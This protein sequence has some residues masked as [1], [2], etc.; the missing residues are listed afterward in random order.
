MKNIFTS[1]DIGSNN[2]K[3]VVCELHNNKLNLLAASS[4]SSKGI[5][6][7][8]IVNADE[9]SKSIKEAFEKVESMLGIK[10]KKVIA[11]IPSYFAEFTYIKGT[12]NVVNEENLIGSDE[13]VDVLGVAMESKLTNDKEMVTIIPVDFKVDDKG[14]I[15][16]PLGHSG[17]LLSARA[18]MVTTPK[19]NI[20]SV[21]SVLENLGIEV[22]DI[23]INGIGNIYSLKTRDMSDLVGAVIDIG[24]ETTTVSLYNKTVIVKNS[25]IGVGSKVLDNDLAFTYKIG[26]DDAKKIKE[27]FA[28]ASKKYASVG[29]FYEVKNEL[30]EDIKINQFEATE[31]VT[32]RLDE[33]LELVK[34]EILSLSGREL[35]Y[36]V[37]TGGMSEMTHFELLINEKFGKKATVGKIRTIGVRNNIYSASLGNIIYF[38][39]KLKLKGKNYSMVSTK[40][41][42]DLSSVKKNNA[43]LVSD[44]MLGKV[45]Q[46]F[47]GE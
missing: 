29:D 37:F 5:K 23:M 34:N 16:N 47:F 25:I 38:V 40:D 4:V 6:R 41:S 13:V 27:T 42:E 24:S 35:D 39:N 14:G 22:I 44:S 26:K 17:K 15:S 32:N 19:K 7:G 33:I 31:V 20:Y 3:V 11:S 30:G 12:V 36:I 18:I 2:I 43:N 8:M 10:I 28:L 45:A 21:V 1:I 9:A 46:Y